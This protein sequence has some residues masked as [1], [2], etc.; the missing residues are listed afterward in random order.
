MDLTNVPGGAPP[1]AAVLGQ[2]EPAAPQP[3][4]VNVV[5]LDTQAGSRQKAAEEAAALA[6]KPD[7]WD[8]AAAAFRNESITRSMVNSVIDRWHGPEYQA[9][10]EYKLDPTW[11]KQQADARG[12][13]E[14]SLGPLKDA[15]SQGH[16]EFLLNDIATSRQD[17]QTLAQAGVVG[18]VTSIG[19][20]I[21]DPV[22]AVTNIAS[23]GAGMLLR[24]TRLARIMKTGLAVGTSNAAM[25][26]YIEQQRYRQDP[27]E[28]AMAGF[29]GF[30]MGGLLGGLTKGENAAFRKLGEN[31]Y[32]DLQLSKLKADG[33]P[34]SPEGEARLA[35]AQ[36]SP[37]E[38]S[39]LAGSIGSGQIAPIEGVRSA[40]NNI[41]IPFTNKTFSLRFDYAA[42]FDRSELETMR[43]MGNRLL[44]D[45]A[46]KEGNYA[47][48][49]N[50]SEHAALHQQI[51]RG[52]FY[53][54]AS[55]SFAAHA[56][57]NDLNWAQRK[58][59]SP[60]ATSFFED[61]TA[62]V[63]GDTQVATRNPEAAQLGEKLSQ[64]HAEMLQKLKDLGVAGAEDV[65]PNP[66]YMMRR[67]NYDNI[68]MLRDEHGPAR[69]DNLV[70][71]ALQSA[72]AD[73]TP[74]KAD[75]IA[76]A[77]V[78]KVRSMQYDKSF[79]SSF[80]TEA[81]KANVAAALKGS[82]NPD[83][84]QVLME[85]LDTVPEAPKVEGVASPRLKPRTK[86]DENY[87]MSYVDKDGVQ[88]TMKVSDLFEND[89]RNLFDIYTRQ[90]TGLMG[91]AKMGIKSPE[92][93]AALRKGVIDEALDKNMAEET[94]NKQLAHM[95]NVFNY[96]R[97]V[98]MANQPFGKME[99]AARVLRDVNFMRMMG[100]SGAA[101]LVDATNLIGLAGWRAFSQQMPSVAEIARLAKGGTLDDSLA[102]TLAQIGGFGTET[103]AH[104]PIWQDISEM[105]PSATMSKVERATK[106]GAH[107][108]SYASG[109]QSINNIE[110]T[111]ASRVFAQKFS[112]LAHG[113]E[114]LTP[115]LRKR[116]ATSGLDEDMLDKVLERMK[117][118]SEVEGDLKSLTDI[119][120][121]AW[122]KQSPA[123]YDAFQMAMFR[124]VRRSI[125]ESTI[126][127]TAPWMHSTLGKVLTQFRSFSIV[128]WN[129]QFLYGMNH[130]SPAVVAAW[131]MS[132]LMGS[133]QYVALTHLNFANDPQGREQRLDPT[134]IALAGFNK[135]GY[136]SILPGMLDTTTGVALGRQFFKNARTSGLDTG[137]VT[138]NPTFDLVA[139]KIGN[140]V[141]AASQSALTN[142]YVWTQKD[143]KNMLGVFPNLY[144]YRNFTHAMSSDFP[145]TNFLRQGQPHTAF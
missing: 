14:E 85:L 55:D 5:P 68:R 113:T 134:Q 94:V 98:P 124:E 59:V 136:S 46:G 96:I 132:T 106:I 26:A 99:R 103:M 13:P 101:Q 131:S 54:E 89:A 81:D 63:R 32:T 93:W 116:L 88:K 145:K 2:Q 100:Q 20:N 49:M 144:G 121:E 12:I 50:A 75:T 112:N 140:T 66:Q 114:E 4:D 73:L 65:K 10:P 3:G 6:P 16:A 29:M 83:E 60:Q 42:I 79:H 102:K 23:G 127:E 64:L 133:L 8:T 53:Q 38:S 48:G 122:S 92:D 34:L 107:A 44:A 77:Y 78:G 39:F 27:H 30:A 17:Q 120:H 56:D 70:S 141:S 52:R 82:L 135:A 129:K 7:M 21:L 24:G 22:A 36:Q 69:L 90:T 58:M 110:K 28:I 25:E 15:V 1:I 138:G 9:D 97:G 72:R 126:G 80:A 31:G 11:A 67:F 123:S 118:H 111:V 104:N 74:E 19:V 51:F 37:E 40:F 87:S 45:G 125:Q 57:R 137:F 84:H 33:I 95:D 62:A 128:A 41:K 115:G 117:M 91:L 119:D 86:L 139:N 108:V 18:A 76:K 130:M 43:D 61:V 71:R 142:D 109:L 35:M 47:A 105:A 143:V